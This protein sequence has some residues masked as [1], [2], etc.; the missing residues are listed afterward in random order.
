MIQYIQTVLKLPNTPLLMS[1]L[2]RFQEFIYHISPSS[3]TFNDGGVPLEMYDEETIIRILEEVNPEMAELIRDYGL[4]KTLGVLDK[5]ELLEGLT[6][7]QM[8]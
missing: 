4:S 7:A 6:A 3:V 1:N 2:A 8:N 5:L